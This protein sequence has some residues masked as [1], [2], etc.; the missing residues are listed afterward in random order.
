MNNRTTQRIATIPARMARVR[1]VTN[2]LALLASGN[3]RTRIDAVAG[4]AGM[5]RADAMPLHSMT[6][7]AVSLAWYAF[8]TVLPR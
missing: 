3:A 2:A 5:A 7:A 4:L 1:R 8:S 6:A